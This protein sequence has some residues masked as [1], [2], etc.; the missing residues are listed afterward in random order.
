MPQRAMGFVVTQRRFVGLG[1][2]RLDR[3]QLQCAAE[4][5]E[6]EV[7]ARDSRLR[8]ED[9]EQQ[10]GE[11]RGARSAHGIPQPLQPIGTHA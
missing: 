10:A 3:R 5:P 7:P 2:A 4:E 11:H 9:D 1:L 8:H 6:M